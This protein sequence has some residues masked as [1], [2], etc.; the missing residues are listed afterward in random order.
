MG[1]RRNLFD[2][3]RSAAIQ[4]LENIHRLARAT[5]AP[6]ITSEVIMFGALGRVPWTLPTGRPCLS[7][8]SRYGIGLMRI[9]PCPNHLLSHRHREVQN[10]SI[11]QHP[12]LGRNRPKPR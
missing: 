3:R 8:A 1:V 12:P 4:N 2:L 10:K 6:A 7:Y 5:Q 11:R 9:D